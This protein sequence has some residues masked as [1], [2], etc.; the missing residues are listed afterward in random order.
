M[1]YK[2]LALFIL[3]WAV[4]DGHPSTIFNED[5]FKLFEDFRAMKSAFEDENALLLK[6]RFERANLSAIQTNLVKLMS[7]HDYFMKMSLHI[8]SSVFDYGNKIVGK[9]DV[10]S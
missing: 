10:T 5:D 2:G 8:L 4:K 6:L 3:F 1:C 9:I 7:H